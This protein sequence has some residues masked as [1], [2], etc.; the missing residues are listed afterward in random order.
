MPGCEQ[1]QRLVREA[2]SRNCPQCARFVRERE[3]RG[4]TAAGAVHPGSMA[5]PLAALCPVCAPETGDELG[6]G[7]QVMGLQDGRAPQRR[8][9]QA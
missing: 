3:S 6:T 9:D 1:V 5:A 7:G 2:R 8:D 4:T